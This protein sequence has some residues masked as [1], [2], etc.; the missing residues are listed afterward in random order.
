LYLER[1]KD[2]DITFLRSNF[3]ST[4]KFAEMIRSDWMVGLGEGV[5]EINRILYGENCKYLPDKFMTI[6]ECIFREFVNPYIVSSL[7][8]FVICLIFGFIRNIK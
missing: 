8:L 5:V 4:K 7:L 2:E 1:K 3:H 6:N